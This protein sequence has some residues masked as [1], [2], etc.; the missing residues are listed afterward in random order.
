MMGLYPYPHHPEV[1][2]IKTKMHSVF[3]AFTGQYHSQGLPVWLPKARQTILAGLAGRVTYKERPSDGLRIR[4][5]FGTGVLNN[6]NAP[7]GALLS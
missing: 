6:A 3:V 4:K 7:S 1:R 5:S 2:I